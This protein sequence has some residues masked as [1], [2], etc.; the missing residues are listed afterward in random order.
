[1][2]AQ[3]AHYDVI[4][5]GGGVNGTG[6]AMDAAGRGLKVLLCEMGDLASAT[7]SASSKLIHGGLR[8]LEH[9]EFRLVRKALSEREALLRNNPHIM[10]PMR[11]RL[12]HRPY[13]RPAWLIRT[14]LFIYDHLARRE[15]LPGSRSITFD[16]DG[17][18]KPDIRRGFEYSDG[19]VDDARLVVLTAM[20]AQ[21]LGSTV[22][23][24]TR[25]TRIRRESGRWQV[26]LQDLRQDQEQVVSARALVNATGP[27]VSQLFSQCL[28]M[29]PPRTIRMVKGS[30]IVVPRLNLGEEAYILQNRDGRVVFV[31]PYEDRFSLIGTTDVDYDGDP[32]QARIS[33]EEIRYL[34]DVVNAHFR[35]PVTEADIVWTYSGVRP[36]LDDYRE[37]AQKASRDYRFELDAPAG[38]PPLL[39]V[40]GGK[41]T[42]YRILAETATDALC[43]F[44]PQAGP[45][46]TRNTPLPGGDFPDRASLA[47][48]LKAG[49]PWLDDDLV[50]RY[51]RTYGTLTYKILQQRHDPEDLGRR[52]SDTLYQAEVDYLVQHE[53]AVTAE[54]I[55]W[56]R[57]KQGLYA[58]SGEVAELEDYLARTTAPATASPVPQQ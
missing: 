19:W 37:A 15:L 58:S 10:H 45:A 47:R 50:R 8:Y 24:R 4:V 31:I 54:D 51:V 48:T 52:F 3:Q 57:T 21:E 41:I 40:F 56:R 20:K 11:F 18:L 38:Q 23:T 46:W 42:T 29:P 34:L 28:N 30:H 32:A 43:R 35:K 33:P 53:W 26:T 12:P 16:A 27:W 39:S 5:I 7:S 2:D 49:Y 1:M 55:L 9:H 36:L 44:F 17:P 14:G 25:C 22:L 13:L 6:I